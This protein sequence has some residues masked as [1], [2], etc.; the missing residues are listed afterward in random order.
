VSGPRAPVSMAVALVTAIAASACCVVPAVLAVVGVSGVGFAARF[1]PYR[2]YFLAAT[3]LALVFGFWL[4]YRPQ[5]DGCGCAVPRSRRAARVGLWTT[6]VLAV[7]LAA[8][9]LLGGGSATAGSIEAA[10]AATLELHVTGMDCAECT[11]TIANRIKRVPGVVSASV[12]FESGI[13]VVR[14]DGRAG[15]EQAAIAAVKKAGFHA[16]VRP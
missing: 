11:S 12:E 13:A 16:E 9:P 7:A 10:A 5:R 8:Y 2:P 15:M 6:T 1:V 3:V 4:A 14:H